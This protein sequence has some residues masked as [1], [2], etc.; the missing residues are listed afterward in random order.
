MSYID[1]LTYRVLQDG[2]DNSY[3]VRKSI[4][5]IGSLLIDDDVND[6]TLV[7]ITSSLSQNLQTVCQ[8]GNAAYNTITNVYTPVNLQDAANKDYVDSKNLEDILSSGNSTG[9]YNI[10]LTENS[11]I[12]SSDGYVKIN[13][14]IDM[15]NHIIT[16]VSNPVSNSDVVTKE[17]VDIL[18]GAHGLPEVL[19]IDNKCTGHDINLTGQKLQEVGTIQF[20]SITLASYKEGQ[21][22][23][24]LNTKS[25]SIQVEGSNTLIA[26]GIPTDGYYLKGNGTKWITSNFV[27]DVNTLIEDCVIGISSSTDNAIVRWDGITGKLI[28]NSL[29]TI[30]DDGSI[31]IPNNKVLYCTNS[32]SNNVEMVKLTSANVITVGDLNSNSSMD[33]MTGGPI[34][35]YTQGSGIAK[36]SLGLA[37]NLDVAINGNGNQHWEL[38]YGGTGTSTSDYGYGFLYDAS[39]ITEYLNGSSVKKDT[40]LWDSEAARPGNNTVGVISA[41]MPAFGQL[42]FVNGSNQYILTIG[43]GN[44]IYQTTSTWTY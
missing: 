11:Y 22:Y 37:L 5:F 10:N 33:I 4:K 41:N 34:V 20:D 43:T 24:D 2:Y 15:N 14:T 1:D 30:S 12:Y 32:T 44:I 7:G 29:V 9:G 31:T 18:I 27:S 23:F 19:S 38:G 17:Y 40:L 36:L 26:A 13:D 8:V 16:N 25:L 3:P 6:R 21:V 42:Q 39:T 35:I 28:Q